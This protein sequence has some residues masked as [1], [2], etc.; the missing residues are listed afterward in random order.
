MAKLGQRK[1]GKNTWGP[2]TLAVTSTPR[3]GRSDMIWRSDVCRQW[4]KNKPSTA[5]GKNR[6]VWASNM[7]VWSWPH[8]TIE[9]TKTKHKTWKPTWAKMLPH[10]KMKSYYPKTLVNKYTTQTSNK[11]TANQ[12]KT[13]QPKEHQEMG[14]QPAMEIHAWW[15]LVCH[16]DIGP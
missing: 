6:K 5:Y 9:W 10:Y 7:A 14:S 11:K 4:W 16:D 15:H 3:S 8:D 12:E 13:K 2:P 1:S